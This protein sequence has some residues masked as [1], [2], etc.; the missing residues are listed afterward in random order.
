MTNPAVYLIRMAAFLVA[1]A[2]VGAET[3]A[4]PA[5]STSMVRGVM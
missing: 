3:T 2:I 4:M 1:V 5:A